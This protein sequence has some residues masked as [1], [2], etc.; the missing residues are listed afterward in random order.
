VACLAVGVGV[1]ARLV[2]AGLSGWGVGPPQE[3]MHAAMVG[4]LERFKEMEAKGVSL[5]FQDRHA[6]NWTP[7]MAAIFHHNTN[8]IEYLLTKNVNLD[9]RDARGETALMGAITAD[10]TNTVRL[11]LEKGANVEIKDGLGLTAFGYAEGS[12]DHRAVILD[13]L[14]GRKKRGH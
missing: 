7:L 6:F 3:L 9:L 11:L 14:N 1:V 8:I 2:V 4:D 5:D 12:Q 10:D 13:W